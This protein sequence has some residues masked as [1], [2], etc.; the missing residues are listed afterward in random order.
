MAVETVTCHTARLAGRSLHASGV[1]RSDH[2][3]AEEPPSWFGD[4]V[5]D[6]TRN[7]LTPTCPHD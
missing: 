3:E 1:A 5:E 2:Y 6:F 7:D 4:P